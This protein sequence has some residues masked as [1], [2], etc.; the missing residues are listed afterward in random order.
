MKLDGLIEKILQDQCATAFIFVC[1][2]SLSIL[3][4][5]LELI[6]FFNFNIKIFKFEIFDSFIQNNLEEI[7]YELVCD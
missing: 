5:A 4:G 6:K 1:R 7:N 2:F 3:A